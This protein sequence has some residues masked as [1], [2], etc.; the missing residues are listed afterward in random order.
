ML[1]NS[2]FD[3][4]RCKL[5]KSGHTRVERARGWIRSKQ[6]LELSKQDRRGQG[7][8]GKQSSNS[9]WRHGGHPPTSLPCDFVPTVY[10]SD[11]RSAICGGMYSFAKPMR[12]CL[13]LG[14]CREMANIPVQ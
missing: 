3:L 11:L 7:G 10:F 9:M 8:E 13:F 6:G 12:D 2:L 5:E 14:N 1:T 4:C